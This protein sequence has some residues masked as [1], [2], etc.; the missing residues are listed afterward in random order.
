MTARPSCKA[1]EID[2]ENFL[3]TAKT[4]D[5]IYRL[6]HKS[7]VKPKEEIEELKA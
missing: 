7:G 2:Y 4:P 3:L 6:T 5:C 1:D